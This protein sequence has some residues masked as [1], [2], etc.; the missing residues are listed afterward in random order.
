MAD[1]V[2]YNRFTSDPEVTK[3]M[4]FRPHQDLVESAAS[5][6]KLQ[7]RY[8]TGD[9]FRWGIA[10]KES[11]QLIGMIDL[12]RFNESDRSCSFAYMLCRDQWNH[13]YGTEAL[14]AVLDFGFSTLDLERI[15]ADHMAENGASGAIMAKSGMKRQAVIPQAYEKDGTKHDAVRYAITRDQWR[16]K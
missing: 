14:R 4:M 13:G 3:F 5:I 15:E 8:A 12:L 11:D 2:D 1:L 10:L 16:Q 9:C 7:Q 6:D